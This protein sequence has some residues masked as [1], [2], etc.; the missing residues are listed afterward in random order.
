MWLRRRVPAF[1]GD[2]GREQ[3]QLQVPC[4][5]AAGEPD[6]LYEQW[7]LADDNE[8]TA[9]LLEPIEHHLE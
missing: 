6:C 2:F 9:R 1:K 5:R 3:R 7:E 4:Q 8:Q